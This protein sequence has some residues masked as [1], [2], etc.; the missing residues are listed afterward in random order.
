M[1]KAQYTVG[2]PLPSMGDI[3]DLL[4][5]RRGLTTLAASV[6]WERSNDPSQMLELLSEVQRDKRVF[7]AIAADIAETTL[8]Y[9]PKMELA[10]PCEAIEVVR[11]WVRGEASIEEVEVVSQK[12]YTASRMACAC[13]PTEAYPI[14]LGA[15][16]QATD[17]LYLHHNYCGSVLA[18][19]GDAHRWGGKHTIY[20]TR[21]NEI[22]SGIIRQQVSIS[23]LEE[24]I[25]ARLAE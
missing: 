17:V 16:F 23:Q 9:I 7:A 19:A 8:R 14:A 5:V 4:K 12:V 20:G 3:L 18:M 1:T 11:K 2:G 24:L 21:A 15:V 10:L 25:R 6:M 22:F 13:A